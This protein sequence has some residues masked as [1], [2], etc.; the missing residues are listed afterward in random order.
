M[1]GR[2][3]KPLLRL[4]SYKPMTF[5]SWVVDY[6][7]PMRLMGYD[8]GSYKKQYDKNAKQYKTANGMSEDEYL[9]KMKKTDKLIPVIT[10]VVYYGEK[11]WDAAKSLHEMLEIPKEWKEFVND[12]KMLLV[13]ARE[14]D[15]K[16]HNINNQD[17]F[18][19]LEILLDT[20]TPQSKIREK[21]MQYSR[22]H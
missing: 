4:G 3:R 7:M 11:P 9:S 8:Y 16:L 13:E 17:L 18:N 5:R 20:K 6:A 22:E 14:N 19:L 21:A 15:L 1:K 12:Y 2:R 10:V